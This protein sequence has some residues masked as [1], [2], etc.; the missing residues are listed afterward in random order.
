MPEITESQV[1]EKLSA[2][3]YPGFSRDILSFG[4]VKE[5]RVSG[6]DVTIQMALT[7][8]DAEVPQQ[9]KAETEEVLKSIPGIGQVTVKIDIQAPARSAQPGAAVSAAEIPGI[10]HVVAVASGKG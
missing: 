7:T 4:L 6:E 1:R 10:K 8:A 3:R 9:I 5:I 2:V